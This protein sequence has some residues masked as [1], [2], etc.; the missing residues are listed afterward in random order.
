MGR[1]ADGITVLNAVVALG[2]TL[3][4]SMSPAIQRAQAR[5][6]GWGFGQKRRSS[7]GSGC[8]RG[9][10]WHGRQGRGQAGQ[11]PARW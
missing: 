5:W 11:P 9:H 8:R 7:N 6:P 2:A 1:A 3:E 4:N 10:R